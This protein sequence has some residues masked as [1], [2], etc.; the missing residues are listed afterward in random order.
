[1]MLNRPPSTGCCVTENPRRR[2]YA[3]SRRPSRADWPV[4]E[5]MST[6]ARVSAMMSTESTESAASGVM[7]KCSRKTAAPERNHEHTAAKCNHEDR[8][9]RPASAKARG[10]RGA[11][12][13]P[14]GGDTAVRRS[15]GEGGRTHEEEHIQC[16]SSCLRVF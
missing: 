12:C 6:S 11:D 7:Q 15:L 9:T 13:A 2:R 14:W 3:A 16:A 10:P 4:V 8:K 5:S 1:M